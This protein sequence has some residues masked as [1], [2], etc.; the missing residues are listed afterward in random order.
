MISGR[1][2][3]EQMDRVSATAP[4]QLRRWLRRG[5]AASLLSLALLAGDHSHLRAEQLGGSGVAPL[6]D[7]D[8]SRAYTPGKVWQQAAQP[9][10]LGWSSAKLSKARAHADEL[11][12][13]VVVIVENGVIVEAWGDLQKRYQSRS[14]RKSYLSVLYGEAIDQKRVTLDTTLRDLDIDDEPPLTRKEREASLF[15]LL[16]ARSG[17]YHRAN[18]ESRAMR[19]KRPSRESHP[20]G[21]YWYYNNW[22]FNAL[23]T[24]YERAMEESVFEGFR[25]QIAEPLDMQYHRREDT[26]YFRGK[27]SI[28]PAYRFRMSPLDLARLGLLYLRGGV[29]NGQRIISEDWIE[30]STRA[31]VDTGRKGFYAGYGFMWWVG[32]DGYAAVGARGQRLFVMPE[33]D[34]VIVHLVDAD[35][36]DRRVGSKKIRGLLKLILAAKTSDHSDVG[37]SPAFRYASRRPLAFDFSGAQ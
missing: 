4:R 29:W 24:I 21:S 1:V 15:D 37:N 12:S 18:F 3:F 11:G 32:K 27:H 31:H 2:L 22:D 33:R 6:S 34:L 25:R 19:R 16:T 28:H 13:S 8:S 14:M 10:L 20:P 35:Q 9:E 36:K 26:K 7:Y 5:A 30:L 17:V 23:G